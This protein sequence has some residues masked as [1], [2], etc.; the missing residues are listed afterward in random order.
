[1]VTLFMR[2]LPEIARP[3]TN[4]YRVMLSFVDRDLGNS[5]NTSC[6]DGTQIRNVLIIS[7]LKKLARNTLVIIGMKQ[8]RD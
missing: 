6:N 7:I 8:H 1:M 5:N 3:A 2:L 4:V